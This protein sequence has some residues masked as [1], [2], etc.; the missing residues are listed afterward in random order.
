MSTTSCT[1]FPAEKEGYEYNRF[2]A[3]NF[4]ECVYTRL[5]VA[6][7]F[8]GMSSL[9]F[10]CCCQLPQIY[11]NYKRKNCSALSKWFLIEWFSGDIL[12]LCGAVL[13]QQ[14][15]TQLATGVL[16]VIVD[17]TMLCQI[18]YYSSS[19]PT[20]VKST[21]LE[22]NKVEEDA[23]DE[24]ESY[25]PPPG[26]NSVDSDPSLLPLSD[27]RNNPFS[28][29]SS[30][31]KLAALVFL[32]LFMINFN[33]QILSSRGLEF[34][35]SNIPNCEP[36]DA[37]SNFNSRLGYFLGWVSAFVYLNSRIPQVL[38]NYKRKSV[39]GLSL[40]MFFCAVMGN[41]T[42]G[43]GVVL[44]D[45]S[46]EALSKSLPWLVGSLGTLTFD[47]FIILQFGFYRE[48]PKKKK[49]RKRR[50]KRDGYSYDGL[51]ESSQN[52]DEDSDETP[53]HAGLFGLKSW[54]TSPFIRHVDHGYAV[55]E[56][57]PQQA[58]LQKT[59]ND[60]NAF[61]EVD[62]YLRDRADSL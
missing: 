11:K 50:K 57:S 12:N 27:T 37:L 13:T 39:E 23:L 14:L 41:V 17:F 20:K 26:L 40:I 32:P 1:C 61:S 10:W 52:E 22:W 47:F 54:T 33:G 43:L 29:P 24:N 16:F 42:Y 30:S 25:F 35:D 21:Q 15:P 49:D 48:S 3:E 9:L 7:F 51:A 34:Q 19:E 60:D 46:P 5:E 31:T 56:P 58:L 62:S 38:K 6:S 36:E 44:K 55:L 8:I 2:I 4:S 18:F 59:D 53:A 45:S 28:R